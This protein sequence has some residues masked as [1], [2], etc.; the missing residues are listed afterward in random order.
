MF[1]LINKNSAIPSLIIQGLAQ[2]N[3][4]KPKFRWLTE[5]SSSG[6]QHLAIKM[7][8]VEHIAVLHPYN[9]L[10]YKVSSEVDPLIFKGSL[11]QDSNVEVLVTGGSPGT[12]TFDVRFTSQALELE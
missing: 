8:D 5:R 9:P 4:P 7:G 10:S 2:A 1:I 6:I 12:D 3:D 11:M